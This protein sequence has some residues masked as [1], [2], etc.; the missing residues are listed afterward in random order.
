MRQNRRNPAATIS[1]HRSRHS[2]HK[3]RNRD[4]ELFTTASYHLILAV[5]RPKWGSEW[6]ARGVLEGMPWFDDGLLTDY[7]V[8][9]HFFNVT[10]SVR[11]H[12]MSREKLNSLIPFVGN[13]D[14]VGKE[15][16]AARWSAS[17]G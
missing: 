3:R 12:P 1:I 11:Y 10:R 14:L 8:A 2:K 6:T 13:S 15:P 4:V 16:L 17:L 7:T 5:H 9:V